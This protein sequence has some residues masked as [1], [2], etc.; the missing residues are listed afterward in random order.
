MIY[1]YVLDNGG[2]A[3]T[4]GY[5]T[6]L[7]GEK[8]GLWEGGFRAVGFVNSPLLAER[9]Q[10]A[11]LQNLMHISDWFPTL[12]GVA[13]GNMDDLPLDGTDMWQSIRYS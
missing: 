11:V 8:G 10:G 2:R 5:N 9:R 7:R 3:R 12:V 1:V 4:G 6:P 13:G